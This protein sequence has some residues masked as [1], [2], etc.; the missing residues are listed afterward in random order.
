MPLQATSGAASYD[1]FGGGVP[2]VPNY[3][4]EVFSTDLY[5]GTGATR[6]ITNGIDLSTKGGM[7]W[8][9]DREIGYDHAIFDT[10]RGA[11]IRVRPNR[12]YAQE[13]T[14][15]SLTAFTSTGFTLGADINEIVNGAVNNKYVSWAFRKQPKF[16]DIQTWTNGVVNHNLGSVP[17]CIIY[18]STTT[19]ENWW[20]L[21]RKSDGTYVSL[22]LNTTGTNQFTAASA[23]AAGITATTFDSSIVFGGSGTLVGYFFAHNAGGFGL[24]GTD[25][26]ISCG[27]FTTDGSGN[28]TVSL[29]YEPQ[30]LLT[31]S[32]DLV[33]QWYLLDSM[34][35][36][37][38]TTA[39][40]KILGSNLA[41][42]ETTGTFGNPT[43]TGFTIANGG[44]AKTYVYVAIRRG[45]MAVPTDATKVFAPVLNTGDGSK[46]L[47]KSN[48]VIAPDFFINKTRASVGGWQ[49]ASRLTGSGLLVSNSTAAEVSGGATWT[50][51]FMNGVR[52]V[53]TTI[54]TQ[55]WH[56]MF[57]RAPSFMD[58]VCF[59]GNGTTQTLAHNLTKVPELLIVKRR[60]GGTGSWATLVTNAGKYGYL[61]LTLSFFNAV[62]GINQFGDGTVYVAPTS[63]QFTVGPDTDTNASSSNYVAYMFA[64]TAGVSKV[65]S[66]TGNG[67]TQTIDCGFGAGGARF[68]LIRRTDTTGDWYLYDTARG[69]TILTDP[70]LFLN[71]TAA[72]VATLGSV[73]TVSTGFALDSTI[74]AAI[75]VS[76]GTY[77]FLAIA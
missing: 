9:K 14:A 36:W 39:S 52:N 56:L 71:T 54:G 68:V 25:N 29:G 30:W 20:V 76:A 51:D 63:T 27:S 16:F 15:D 49:E 69:M 24:T 72:E 31:K 59:S 77:I 5:T 33:D 7:V 13:T 46:P 75:N 57:K 67:S 64:T 41:D 11:T 3:I 19:V 35:G 73:T 12:D 66:Y 65:G 8:F 2:A 47:Y 1:A 55:Y 44:A 32:T 38:V 43:A 6:T 34:R 58:I 4:E 48:T 28:A 26:V 74:L 10:V 53:A 70:Y 17:G 21:S 37:P 18:K 22:S 50:W 60:S 61:N 40:T 62:D 42:P 23:A 45:P